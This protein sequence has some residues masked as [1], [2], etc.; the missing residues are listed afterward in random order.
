MIPK[1]A[2]ATKIHLRGKRER[3]VTLAMSAVGEILQRAGRL[4]AAD[5]AVMEFGCGDGFQIPH[6]R[7]FG[8]VSASDLY[9]SDGIRAMT[10]LEFYECRIEK[11][12]FKDQQFDLI[13]SNQVFQDIPEAVLPDIYLELKRILKPGGLLAFTVPTNHW[14]VLRIPAHYWNNFRF[15]WRRLSGK[16][17]GAEP[18]SSHFATETSGVEL[19]QKRESKFSKA[20]KLFLPSGIGGY[21]GFWNAYRK[22]SVTSWATRFESLG[23][24]LVE[25]RP[26]LIY[27]PS[28]W[29]I[30]P[31][32]RPVGGICS[33]VLIVLRVK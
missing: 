28:E 16:D 10:D 3:E 9:C 20:V 29:P 19:E 23:F 25:S 18:G 26:L 2:V 32:M 15:V 31:T 5:F 4:G 14:L 6:L 22:M 24:E 21:P 8:K 13:Y 17:R 12:P 7:K 1:S 27:A 11:T 30:V 33:S